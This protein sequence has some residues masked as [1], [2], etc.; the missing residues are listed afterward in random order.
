MVTRE[1]FIRGLKKKNYKALDY[2]VENYANLIFKV[3]YSVLQNRELAEEC[4]N[5]VFLKIWDNAIYFNKENNQFVKWIMVISK[6][7]AI[8]RLR[9][10]IRQ[11]DKINI[12]TLNVSAIEKLDESL[13]IK[14]DLF[15]VKKEIDN[16]KPLEKEIFLR[17]FY[18]DQDTKHISESLG[19]SE[20]F[21]NLKIFR[22]RKKLREK[23]INKGC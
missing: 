22:G 2:V 19:K 18:L 10:E 14:D 20:K 16:M 15:K 6:Y 9:K 8:D 7:T 12:E 13:E 21:I 11:P 23:L 5:D 3:S 1:N 17:K 4:M